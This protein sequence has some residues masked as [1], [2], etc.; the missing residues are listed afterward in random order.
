M[1]FGLDSMT[2]ELAS[3]P[4]RKE[5]KPARKP[6]P[7]PSGGGLREPDILEKLWDTMEADSRHNKLV[8]E[9]QRLIE[10]LQAEKR[11]AEHRWQE[12]R[13]RAYIEKHRRTILEEHVARCA[14][15]D[16]DARR[17][18]EKVSRREH[19]VLDRL[20][21]LL[22][23]RDNRST[24]AQEAWSRGGVLQK[25][26]ELEKYAVDRDIE[27]HQMQGQ[28]TEKHNQNLAL[29]AQLAN[30]KVTQAQERWL[31]TLRDDSPP[32]SS[33][34]EPSRVRSA[35]APRVRRSASRWLEE[36][37]ELSPQLHGVP[38]EESYHRVVSESVEAQW[39]GSLRDDQH[40]RWDEP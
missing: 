24:G 11:H 6:A 10:E 21:L 13:S 12:W 23:P 27:G 19:A 9:Q 38:V 36:S 7:P 37:P 20:L 18:H 8:L 16:M 34:E 29:T 14:P 1:S 30:A 32:L 28:L 25:L 33:S 22:A 35:S 39:R 2:E 17:V 40:A 31:S 3:R 5:R 26:Q 15:T 4:T